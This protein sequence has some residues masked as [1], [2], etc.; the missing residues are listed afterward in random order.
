MAYRLGGD[1]F[2]VFLTNPQDQ[3]PEIVA[4]RIIDA[5][6][7][8]FFIGSET[9]DF[10]RASIGISTYPINAADVETLLLCADKA[11]YTAK[12]KGNSFFVYHEIGRAHV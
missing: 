12:K 10:V 9:I 3:T 8:P 1:E 7:E 11:M 2:A 6:A 4:Q 5:M